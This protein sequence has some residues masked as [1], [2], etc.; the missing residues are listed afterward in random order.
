MEIVLTG[1][2]GPDMLRTYDTDSAEPGRGQVRVR[3]LA[4]GVSFAEVQMLGHRYPMQ[5]KYPFVPGYDLVGEVTSVGQEVS[6]V[7]VGDRVAAL[8]VTGAWRTH[9]LV[10]A[11]RLVPV[12]DGLDSG[13]AAADRDE[14]G[15]NTSTGR[16]S[17]VS[18][19][20]MRAPMPRPS[21][22]RFAISGLLLLFSARDRA[23]RSRPLPRDTRPRRRTARRTR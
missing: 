12:P 6:G 23:A 3:V 1:K 13:V 20:G 21:P 19:V 7:A 17:V 14:P 16:A 2:G 11:S 5:P 4:S 8:M 18:C 10:P 22:V 9:V 15:K